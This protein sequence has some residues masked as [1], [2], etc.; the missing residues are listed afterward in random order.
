MDLIVILGF[1]GTESIHGRVTLSLERREERSEGESGLNKGKTKAAWQIT[2]TRVKQRTGTCA[3]P[4][5]QPMQSSPCFIAA[6]TIAG[7]INTY[8]NKLSPKL[9][10]YQE[11]K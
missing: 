7:Y 8:K 2:G 5:Q 11:L 1:L 9:T 4:A 3:L 10:L 6:S